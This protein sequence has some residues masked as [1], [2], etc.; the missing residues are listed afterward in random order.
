MSDCEREI[1]IDGIKAVIRNFICT[2]IEGRELF[3]SIA[4]RTQK[5]S[6]LSLRNIT[7]PF[8]IGWS[9]WKESEHEELDIARKRV[10]FNCANK[11]VVFTF[12]S[13]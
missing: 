11:L 9:T 7:F 12:A 4:I 8:V 3:S 10:L 5:P 13:A 2:S 6:Y 1:D